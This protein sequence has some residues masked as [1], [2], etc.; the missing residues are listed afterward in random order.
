MVDIRE[1]QQGFAATRAHAHRL[2]VLAR[3]ALRTLHA[4]RQTRHREERHP[5]Q[6]GHG[7]EPVQGSGGQQQ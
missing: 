4:L 1:W 6:D 7:V 3:H 5:C 2:E